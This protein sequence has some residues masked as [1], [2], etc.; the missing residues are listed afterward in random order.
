MGSRTC[1]KWTPPSHEPLVFF[2]QVENGI[3]YML[4]K[5]AAN[6]KSNQKNL[7]VIQVCVC[8]CVC[9]CV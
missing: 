1:C 8:V 3:P 2:L 5:D 4:Y 9:V 7:G 6:S